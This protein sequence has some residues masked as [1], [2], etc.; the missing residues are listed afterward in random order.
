MVTVVHDDDSSD[1]EPAAPNERVELGLRDLKAINY[2]EHA[3]HLR[4]ASLAQGGGALHEQPGRELSYATKT[5]T[6]GASSPAVPIAELG[7]EARGTGV[8]GRMRG[9][10]P[11]SWIQEAV[12]N[13]PAK[14]RWWSD[15]AHKATGRKPFRTWLAVVDELKSRGQWESPAPASEPHHSRWRLPE[16]RSQPAEEAAAPLDKRAKMLARQVAWRKAKKDADFVALRDVGHAVYLCERRQ[17]VALMTV[18]V[19]KQCRCRTKGCEGRF[20]LTGTTTTGHGGSVVMWFRCSG[21]PRSV[22]FHGSSQ[23]H[24]D[25][26][27]G[28]EMGKGFFETV[29]LM[30]VIT[31][32]INGELYHTYAKSVARRGGTPYRDDRFRDAINWLF[33]YVEKVLTAQCEAEHA[34]MQARAHTY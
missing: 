33:P 26:S 19:P 25:R 13:Y 10:L 22:I 17:I 24:L 12:P 32:L 9:A 5:G 23:L 28:G 11:A 29:G 16:S 20:C 6:I 8:G 2:D 34:R 30:E 4:S 18:E 15:A 27:F 31:S 7:N 14:L 1:D 3:S 21:C